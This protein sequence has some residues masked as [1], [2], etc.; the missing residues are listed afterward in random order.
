MP[1]AF[2]YSGAAISLN[3]DRT[4]YLDSMANNI[5]GDLDNEFKPFKQN[6]VNKGHTSGD[7]SGDVNVLG[8]GAMGSVGV[9]LTPTNGW[10]M[11]YPGYF[12]IATSRFN[13]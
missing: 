7:G 6:L 1:K 5:K 2:D 11:W 3:V 12:G 4:G 8:R 10:S 13:H 9:A